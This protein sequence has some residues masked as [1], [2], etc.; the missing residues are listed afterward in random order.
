MP[1]RKLLITK[2]GSKVYIRNLNKDQHTKFGL[3]KAKDLK[4]NRDKVKSNTGKEFYVLPASFI[5][6]FIKIKRLAQIILPKDIATIITETGINKKSRVVDAGAG[7][8][9][10]ACYLAHICKRVVTY[11]TRKDFIKLVESNKKFLG[12]K[13]LKIK[14]GD[15][16]KRISEKN[17]DLVTLDLPEP[18]KALNNAA[19]TLNIGGY[20]VAYLPQIT[21]VL[22][23]VRQLDKHK[24]FVYLK[25]I[26][27][28]QRRWEIYGRVA[29]PESKMIGHTAFLVFARR[30]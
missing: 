23:F 30:I 6:K 9:A 5:D 20:L 1:I 16:Y 2:S 12:I 15:V 8:G 24:R 17:I 19:K 11:D 26:E 4:K 29:R 27:N 18:W 21:Q 7:S 3:I 22:E 10:L 14:Y 13:N 25:T 28:I